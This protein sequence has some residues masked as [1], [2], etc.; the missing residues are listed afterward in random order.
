MEN[1][2]ATSRQISRQRKQ[3]MELEKREIKTMPGMPHFPIT[4]KGKK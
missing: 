4:K 1:I 2:R 3:V